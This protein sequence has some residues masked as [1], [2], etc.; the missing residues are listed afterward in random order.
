[1]CRSDSDLFARWVP[2]GL[3]PLGTDGV[4]RGATREELRRVFGIDAG[5]VALA[6]LAELARRGGISRHV[7]AL[8]VRELDIDPES[9]NPLTR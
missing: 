9:A 3:L 4:G 2:Q 5:H 7:A 1:M 6:A 8:A